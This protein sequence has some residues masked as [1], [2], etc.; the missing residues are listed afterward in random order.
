MDK[1]KDCVFSSQSEYAPILYHQLHYLQ[2]KKE[3]QL[4]RKY[5]NFPIQEKQ[6]LMHLLLQRNLH[7]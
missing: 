1:E 3:E 6:T 7:S 4:N 5:Q 2:I